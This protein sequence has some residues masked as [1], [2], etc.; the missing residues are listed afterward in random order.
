M[1]VPSFRFYY[2]QIWAGSWVVSDPTAMVKNTLLT[3]FLTPA[4]PERPY[5]NHLPVEKLR[6]TIKGHIISKG[7]GLNEQSA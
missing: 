4:K 1:I 6:K 3:V 2:V 7:E 5:I